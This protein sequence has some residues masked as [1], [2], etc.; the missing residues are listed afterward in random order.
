MISVD[1]DIEIQEITL[2]EPKRVHEVVMYLMSGDKHLETNYQHTI[3]LLTPRSGG[4][5]IVAD[6]SYAQY[7]FAGGI[8]TQEE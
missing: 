7:S 8:D 3:L 6:A 1:L 2:D 4:Q 5:P